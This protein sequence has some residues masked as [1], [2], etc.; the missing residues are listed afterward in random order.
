MREGNGELLQRTICLATMTTVLML[1]LRL[2][3]SKRS[4]REGPSKSM[5]KML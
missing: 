3:W 1:N 4:S 5:T 2:Q